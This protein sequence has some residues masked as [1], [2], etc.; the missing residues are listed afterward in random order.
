MEV[1]KLRSI[2]MRYIFAVAVGILF[3]IAINFGLYML[4]VNTEV[5]IPVVN[6]EN[7]IT[8]AT[9]KIQT[10]E[11]FDAADIPNFCDYAVYSSM[12]AFKYGSLSEETANTFWVEAVTNGQDRITPYRVLVIDHGDEVILLRYR[13]TSQF[14]NAMLRRICPTADLLLVG[15]III[16]VVILL[17]L[18]SYWFGKYAGRKIDKLLLITQKIEQQLSLIHI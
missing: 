10:N 4:C 11:L 9:E 2:F 1:K 6:I 18:V 8:A 5:I 16:E 12:G 7:R 13:L 17:F 3:I 14:S 15:L